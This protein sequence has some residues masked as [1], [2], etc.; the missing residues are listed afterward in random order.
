MTN[1]TIVL[2]GGVAAE[3]L[4]YLGAGVIYRQVVGALQRIFYVSAN[5]I[6]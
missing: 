1:T 2:A 3:S 6:S 5:Q 4:N